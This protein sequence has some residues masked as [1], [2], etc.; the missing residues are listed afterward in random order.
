MK[1]NCV[2]NGT[3]LQACCGLVGIKSR[4]NQLV[5]ETFDQEVIAGNIVSRTSRLMRWLGR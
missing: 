3:S 2:K 5:R 4:S 1:D